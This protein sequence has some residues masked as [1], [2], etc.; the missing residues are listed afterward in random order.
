MF[1]G[2]AE[3]SFVEFDGD[4]LHVRFGFL[5]DERIPLQRI[6]SV[7]RA[8]WPLIGG[9]GWRTNFI[10]TVALVGSYSDVVRLRLS[11][12]VSVRMLTRMNCESLYVSVADPDALVAEVRR[13]IASRMS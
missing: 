8:R 11:P 3:R 4:S 5:F 2:T 6:S 1:G 9:L 12:P 13:R 10:D 7:E